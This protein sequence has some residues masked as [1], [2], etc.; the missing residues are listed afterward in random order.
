M[1]ISG[2]NLPRPGLI[3][4]YPTLIK[5]GA[6]NQYLVHEQE[7]PPATGAGHRS[8]PAGVLRAAQSPDHFH[9]AEGVL[10]G[11]CWSSLIFPVSV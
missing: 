4:L 8:Q 9:L 11:V 5:V 1:N 10:E 6:V 7:I 3:E 2:S